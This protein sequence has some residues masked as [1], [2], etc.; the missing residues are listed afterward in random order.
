[1]L[2]TARQETVNPDTNILHHRGNCRRVLSY[3]SLNSS[4][5]IRHKCTTYTVILDVWHGFKTR[6]SSASRFNI[7]PLVSLA[8]AECCCWTSSVRFV[9]YLVGNRHWSQQVSK[10]KLTEA[11]SGIY[12]WQSWWKQTQCLDS[13]IRIFHMQSCITKRK[14][15]LQV[16]QRSSLAEAARNYENSLQV[17]LFAQLSNS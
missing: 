14:Q 1:M 2:E 13:V 3:G 15:H 9:C 10:G 11:Q 5:L 4:G 16:A 7:T 12:H 17:W 6:T 8:T